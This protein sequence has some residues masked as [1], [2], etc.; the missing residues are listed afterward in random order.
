MRVL[1]GPAPPYQRINA[2]H[3]RRSESTPT[4]SI[5]TV[6]TALVDGAEA[7]PN[8]G[9][10]DTETLKF[11]EVQDLATLAGGF[12]WSSATFLS[13]LIRATSQVLQNQ[14]RSQNQ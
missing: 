6:S 4:H 13:E 7:A 2:S 12:V 8:D 9:V 10:A 11:A 5:L 1:N 14:Q 3:R